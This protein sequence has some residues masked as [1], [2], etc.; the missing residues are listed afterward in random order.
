MRAP[1]PRAP[2]SA[3]AI[4]A[5]AACG[6]APPA[7]PAPADQPTL[8]TERLTRTPDEAF[9]LG[10]AF[11]TGQGLA[12]DP[13]RAALHYG[14]ACASEHAR[15]C[16]NLG[17]LLHEGR[18]VTADP[19]AA[20]GRFER[21]CVLGDHEGC[22]NL[23][24]ALEEGQGRSADPPAARAL[25]GQACAA[26]HR[27]ACV[28]HAVMA[29]AGRGGAKDI[30]AAAA[31]FDRACR[32]DDLPACYNLGVIARAAGHRDIAHAA[33]AKA[34]AGGVARACEDPPRSPTP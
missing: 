29:L 7:A 32:L 22:F 33:L 30:S 16:N 26:G 17:V 3:A 6:G 5:L 28:N 25:F 12:A 27:D 18:G 23:A 34:C 1:S 9:T 2:L 15:A 11:E 10:V 14:A 13:A 24:L 4:L 21:A 20:V 8:R 19:A 31:S